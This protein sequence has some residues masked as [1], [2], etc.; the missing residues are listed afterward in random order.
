MGGAAQPP[1]LYVIAAVYA[2]LAVLSSYSSAL[3]VNPILKVLSVVGVLSYLRAL[4]SSA[5]ALE[6]F[7]RRS[8]L[9]PFGESFGTLFVLAYLPF[10]IWALYPRVKVLLADAAANASL[11]E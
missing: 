6:R 7:E 8:T 3:G 10:G 2:V 5:D 1:I 9:V 11:V 4:W